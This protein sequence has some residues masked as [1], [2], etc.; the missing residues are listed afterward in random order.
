M[1]SNSQQGTQKLP[2]YFA[3]TGKV[4]LVDRIEKSDREWQDILT[5]DHI[6][7]PGW[8]EQSLPSRESITTFTIK[9][10]IDAYA[11]VQTCLIR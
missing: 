11:V 4:E 8:Q 6:E 2:I 3:E 9:E 10:F 7:L 1:Q 5:P